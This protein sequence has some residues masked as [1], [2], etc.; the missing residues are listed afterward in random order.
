MELDV[1]AKHIEQYLVNQLIASGFGEIFKKEI[2]S[3]LSDYRFK[4]TIERVI[5]EFAKKEA[6]VILQKDKNLQARI[7]D[8]IQAHF[9]N[10]LIDEVTKKL[11][12]KDY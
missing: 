5:I 3:A 12:W 11:T 10:V 9:E 4:G 1:D 8:S 6:L 2:E 7:K